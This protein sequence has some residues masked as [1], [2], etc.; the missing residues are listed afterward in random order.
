MLPSIRAQLTAW[1]A[2]LVTLCL[3]AFAVYL[4]VA[5]GQLLIA[6]LD[7]M[8]RVQAQQVATTYDFQERHRGGEHRGPGQ[9]VHGRAATVYPF[10]NQALTGL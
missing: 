10:C 2:L 7:Q 6:D 8:L 3:A 1:L 4:Y 9:H 5:V